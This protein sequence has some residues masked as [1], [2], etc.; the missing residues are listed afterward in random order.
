VF[1]RTIPAASPLNRFVERGIAAERAAQDAAAMWELPDFVMAPLAERKGRGVREISD[2]LLVVG[3]QGL[4]VQVRSRDGELRSPEKEVGWIAKK[5]AEAGRQVD[6]TVR[7]S[8]TKT[9]AMVNGRGRTIDITGANMNWT[10]VVIID[11]PAVP[12]N[13]PTPELDTRTPTAPQLDFGMCSRLDDVTRPRFRSWLFLRHHERGTHG[14]DLDTLTTV[15][16]LLTPRQDDYRDWDTT[17][18]AITGDPK[19]TEEELRESRELWNRT[20]NATP[21]AGGYTS[22]P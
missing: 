10:G 6:G 12:E 11:H 2:G 17:L 20:A 18:V 15:G 16:V 21:E 4:V 1:E 22:S 5:I 14:G 3:D 13:L 8:S 7:R 9:T 19:L